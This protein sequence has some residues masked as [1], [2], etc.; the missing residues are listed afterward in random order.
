MNMGFEAA[1]LEQTWGKVWEAEAIEE[2]EVP[3]LADP[4]TMTHK[5]AVDRWLATLPAGRMCEMGSG[6]GQWTRYYA[7]L[8]R[9]A[10]GL[11]V[12]TEAVARASAAA[13]QLGLS[14]AHFVVGDARSM[15]FETSSFIGLS[16]FGVIEHFWDDDLRK[17]LGE[18]YRVLRPGGSM[19]LSTPN[20][21]AAHTLTRPILQ[22]AGKW[23]LGLE[24]SF[25]P[26]RLARYARESGFRIVECGV[27]ESGTLFGL[28]LNR[29]VPPAERLS[30]F[31]ESRQNTFGFVS[32]VIAEK[33]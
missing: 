6:L 18:S 11:D 25:S 14:A 26:K 20:I 1:D 10:V 2:L 32:Y 15:P 22:M 4:W 33:Q 8:G 30:R 28:V 27:L 9:E 24:R 31:I 12:V 7:S 17:M 3:A 21:W 5:P 23:H 13:E 29:L 16:S 19:L